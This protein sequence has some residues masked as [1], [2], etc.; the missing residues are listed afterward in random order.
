MSSVSQAA[1]A[2]PPLAPA[3]TASEII[4]EVVEVNTNRCTPW[5]V[6]SSSRLSVPVILTATKSSRGR[7]AMSG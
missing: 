7:R 4:S 5:R 2:A 3:R 1:R 6:A